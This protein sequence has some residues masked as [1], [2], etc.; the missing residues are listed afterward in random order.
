M[1]TLDDDINPL[2]P[3]AQES[4][5]QPLWC[6]VLLCI[7]SL[8]VYLF[9]WF[10]KHWRYLK[11]EKQQD[12]SP[13]W[14]TLFSIFTGYSLFSI[15]KGLAK[16]QGY[17]GKAPYGFL[18]FCYTIIIVSCQIRGFEIMLLPALFSFTLFIPA[19]KMMNYV[20][21]KEQAGFTSRESLG[22][23]E[24]LFL[25]VFWAILLLAIFGP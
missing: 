1:P 13:G 9:F 17:Q 7:L 18:L 2:D 6:F 24:I 16:E 14:R 5:Y 15:F 3:P 20:Y 22:K 11:D 25:G 8:N 19:H 4:E 23:D 10:Y 12:L 21:E